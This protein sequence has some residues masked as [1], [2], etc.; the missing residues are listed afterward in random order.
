MQ[1]SSDD[2]KNTMKDVRISNVVVS[3]LTDPKQIVHH[4]T[5]FKDRFIPPNQSEKQ[6]NAS[7]ENHSDAPTQVFIVGTAHVS[8]KSVEEVRRIIETEQPDV[9]A[10]ELCP[11]RYKGLTE[12]QTEK[13]ISAKDIL[14]SGNI[15][16]NLLYM[17]LAHI[18]KKM[19]DE[20][21]VPPGSEMITAIEEAQASETA[22]VLIDRDIKITF[23][24][25]IGKMSFWEK[26][27]LLFML[28]GSALGF[29]PNVDENIDIDSLTHQDVIAVLL[30][31]FRKYA[32]TVASVLIDE[33]DAYIAG[34]IYETVRYIGPGHKVVVV[35]GAGHREGVLKYLSDPKIIPPLSELTKIPKKRFP[36]G[37]IIASTI[38]LIVFFLFGYILYSSMTQPE[39][40]IETFFKAF[41]WWFLINGILSAAGAALA[42]GH[43]I[44]VATAFCVSW[45]T[46]LNPL[47]A[48]G[49][50]SGIV[51]AKIRKPT[52]KDMTMVMQAES[53][54][55]MFQNKFFRVIFVAA[56]TNVGSV[57]GTFL[58]GYI[59]FQI[60]GIDIAKIITNI[61][62]SLIG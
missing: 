56:L 48:A 17:L 58:G 53:F 11:S 33:R 5:F 34:S 45:M 10:V 1:N 14:S 13:E 60:S 61:F 54:K 4:A 55:E 46:S 43:Y 23:Q 9:V 44:S 42:G 7:E 18:Q 40:T 26:I 41:G 20:M 32:P 51:E 27:K 36:L 6:M 59:V 8:E 29:G 2:E 35:I 28:G 50:F 38:V 25:F 16:Y 31:D 3:D 30:E 21:G 49:W 39:M 22:I 47:L 62:A 24:R 37:K 52:T 19:G 57:I 12:P 15:F